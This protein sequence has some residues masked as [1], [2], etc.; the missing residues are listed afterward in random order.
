[1]ER[2]K[3]TY[4]SVT[5][6]D[7]PDRPTKEELVKVSKGYDVAICGMAEE[8]DADVAAAA[9]QLKAIGTLS[10]GLD[11]LDLDALQSAGVSVVSV[12][13]ANV[14]SVAEHTWMFIL[15]L[16]KRLLESHRSVVEGS[17]RDSLNERPVDVSGRTLGIVGAG[18]IAHEVAKQSEAFDTE[19]LVWTFNPDHHDEFDSLAVT[20][21]QDLGYL[22]D[23]SDVVTIH[24]PLSEKTEDII[25]GDLL[26]AVDN[27]KLRVLVNTSRA[28]IVADEVYNQIG[29]GAFD[30][31]GLDVFPEDL[32]T[33]VSDRVYFTPH[34]AGITQEAS[35]RMRE[36]ILRRLE[37]TL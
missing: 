25:D 24:L 35:D 18:S 15:S 6:H 37:E 1:M 34:T 32:P 13:E 33:R 14:V 30:A 36:E 7:G 22:I 19:T 28:D 9:N 26:A 2:L 31:A 23:Q 20:F 12:E 3:K 10:I 29:K 27:E 5:V 17:G 4:G 21:I 8:F 16:H 11:H